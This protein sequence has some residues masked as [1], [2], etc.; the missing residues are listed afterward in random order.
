MSESGAL[1]SFAVKWSGKEYPIEGLP[2]SSTLAELK[3]LLMEKTGVRVERQKILG[4]K[5]K[6]MCI[7]IGIILLDFSTK[8]RHR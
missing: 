8:A 5:C 6:G 1:P 2:D 4:L 7:Q 3:Q